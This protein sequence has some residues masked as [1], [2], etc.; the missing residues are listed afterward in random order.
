MDTPAQPMITAN[1]APTIALTSISAAKHVLSTPACLP[2][3]G[4]IVQKEFA[5]NPQKVD[6]AD[7]ATFALA[8]YK[9]F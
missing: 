5:Q 9:L 6:S 2:M 4:G 7:A 3:R 8:D 1:Q